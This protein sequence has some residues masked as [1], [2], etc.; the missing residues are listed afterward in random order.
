MKWKVIYIVLTATT[1][2]HFFWIAAQPALSQETIQGFI[3]VREVIPGI[4]VDLK[5]AGED[6]VFGEVFYT[7]DECLLRNEVALAL[8]KVQN[9]LEKK[10]LQ[11]VI[12]D[13]YRPLSVQ[14]KMWHKVPDERYVADPK[15]GSRHNRGAA[16]DV[17]LADSTGKQL[18]MPTGFDDF[19]KKAHRNF[20][21]ENI[22]VSDN[23][24]LL[25]DVMVS[26]GFIPLPTE[27]W[28]F[29]FRG[30]EKYPIVDLE[31]AKVGD[32]AN[33]RR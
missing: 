33:S 27:W 28:H 26:E 11:L 31:P 24:K 23:A 7:S 10:G 2:I 13:A 21:G 9:R 5:Y 6:N 3:E 22:T 15:K 16:V 8:M 12:W 1:F 19:S 18:P 29:D 30:W 14:K 20:M 32:D 25:E 4:I 17:T